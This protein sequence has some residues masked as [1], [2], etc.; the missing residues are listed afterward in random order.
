MP[1]KAFL[2]LICNPMQYIFP[3]HGYVPGT[4]L[5]ATDL[6]VKRTQYLSSQNV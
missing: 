4:L 1:S 2:F 6:I 5:D 3:N